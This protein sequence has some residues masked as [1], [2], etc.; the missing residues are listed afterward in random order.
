MMIK[1]LTSGTRLLCL[2]RLSA[3][4]IA[5]PDT[6]PVGTRCQPNIAAPNVNT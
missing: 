4:R 6:K 3:G 1:V 5:W 2:H